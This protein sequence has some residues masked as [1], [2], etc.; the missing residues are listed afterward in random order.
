MRVFL[1]VCFP[2]YNYRKWCS[3]STSQVILH[4]C[5]PHFEREF[6]ADELQS[7]ISSGNLSHDLNFIMNRN[8]LLEIR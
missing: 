8:L 2:K 4:K 3:S 7:C 1:S 5:H 6:Y